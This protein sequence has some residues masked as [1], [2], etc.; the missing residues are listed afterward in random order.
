MFVPQ[1]NY[2]NEQVVCEKIFD[3]MLENLT[4]WRLLIKILSFALQFMSNKKEELLNY[5]TYKILEKF[6][7]TIPFRYSIVNTVRYNRFYPYLFLFECYQNVV[8]KS[9]CLKI[10]LSSKNLQTLK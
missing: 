9:F 1:N 3:K 10:F 2:K 4:D 8:N 7:F 5:K 6:R